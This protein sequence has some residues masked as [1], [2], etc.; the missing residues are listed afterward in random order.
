MG[1]RL[2]RQGGAHPMPGIHVHPLLQEA[3]EGGEVAR[4]RRLEKSLLRLR[5]QPSALSVHCRGKTRV[6]GEAGRGDPSSQGYSEC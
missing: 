1:G 2:A 4:T 6:C 5:A 3:L